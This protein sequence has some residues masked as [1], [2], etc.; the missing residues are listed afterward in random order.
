MRLDTSHSVR[1][2]MTML[3]LTAGTFVMYALPAA[4][5]TPDK[6]TRITAPVTLTVQ[7]GSNYIRIAPDNLPATVSYVADTAFGPIPMALV[8]G[9]TLD[10]QMVFDTCHIAWRWSVEEAESDRIIEI[11]AHE[12]AKIYVAP[13][14]C[15]VTT[16]DTTATS[17]GSY[18]WRGTTYS[19]TGDYPI[20]FTNAAGC[21]SIRTLRLTVY[22]QPE[23]RDTNAVVWDSI[24]WY[25][26][27]YKQ[28]GDFPIQRYDANGCDFTHTLH[29][30]VHTTTYDSYAENRC[31]S[32]QY[33]G[34]KYT[35]TGVYA[36]TV[37]DSAGN[38][39]I[40]T[41]SLTIPHS[42]SGEEH[43]EECDTYTWHGKTYTASG[44][45]RDTIENVAGCD[46]IVT[47]YLTIHPSSHNTLPAI[48]ECDS[49][50]WGDTTIYDSG[51]YTRRFTSIHGCDSVV[52]QTITV[53]HPYYDVVDR[54]TAYDSYTWI[55]GTT[56]TSSKT[57]PAY[58]LSTVDGC[59]SLITLDLTIRHLQVKDTFERTLCE[60]YMPYDWYGK[61]YRESGVYASDTIQGKEVGGIYMDTV[62]YVN[63]TV[64]PVT[65]GDTT[66]TA[67]ESFDWHGQTYTASGNYPLTLTNVHGC[68]STV[69]LHLT[70]LSKTR[71]DTTATACESFDWHGQNYTASGDYPLTLT[72]AAGC[73]S[74]VT[75]HLTIAHPTT[76]DT[77]ATA[78]ESFHW[79]GQNYTS[80]GDYPFTLTSAAGCDST[81][82][83]HLTISR[84]LT[85]DTTATACES[86]DWHG[87]N[88]T[89]SGDYPF[90]LTSTEGCDS[91]VTL[92]LTINHPTTGDTT[93]TACESF[94]W[95]GASYTNS[96]DYSHALTN[97]AG[98]DSTV[99]LHLTIYKPTTGDTTA[100]A[101]NAFTWYGDTYISS[102]NYSRLMPG[103]NSHG[104]DSTLI[105]HLTISQP[106]TGE[107]TRSVCD[108]VQWNGQ[109]YRESGNYTYSTQN[110][111]G[112]DS[113]ATLHLTV[114]HPTTDSETR[115]ACVS[116]LWHGETYRTS[117]E[118][119]FT[120]TNAAGCDSVVT[121][122]LTIVDNC[123]TYDTVY[124]CHGL[125]TEHEEKV[126]D[127]LIRRYVP[128]SYESPDEW[129]SME[130]VFVRGEGSRTLLDL[131]RAEQNLYAHYVDGL[132]P[133]VS[134][135]WS[136]RPEGESAYRM[137]A[138]EQEAQ[139]VEAGVIALQV[140][141]L[142]GHV[143]R[144]NIPTDVETVN[145]EG[146]SGHKMLI[147]GELIILR[148]GVKYTI[149]GNKIR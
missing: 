148:G 131:H 103:A 64:L 120:L 92:H 111:A 63:L 138:A 88:Y 21:D 95:Y 119:S 40:T 14:V 52:T 87:Q 44:E 127:G 50:V 83:L 77:T 73:D 58:S 98:C 76:G 24:S 4:G 53:G 8:T 13:H 60:T 61:S 32:I 100:T 115:E 71:G 9:D 149:L 128:Y 30:T 46:S 96:G 121:L 15:L 93:A 56:Y 23:N 70:I 140:Q 49:Y 89:S 37:Y 126:T 99:T 34:K 69:T 28:S 33:N 81:V 26:T 112:C 5:I 39:T 94:T 65:T 20:T 133:V 136:Y 109:W 137:L 54:V 105:L 2:L 25:G 139:W 116:Y 113:T 10:A 68:D 107:E 75:L 118:Y 125:N 97:A 42:S 3:L 62:H 132:E 22:P 38:R 90:T 19:A 104:C 108:S 122:Y 48:T 145:E 101:C 29:L 78:C 106:S 142:C 124:F 41:L 1:M 80:S 82:T 147:N 144:S 110:V 16:S 6:A 72:N 134:I 17:C 123:A 11:I 130:G 59:D 117:G 146:T 114:N 36:D 135:H 47:L 143:Y 67:C 129:N 31:D 45:Y 27:T 141:F 51:T 91:T 86:F 79:Y 12:N 35:E 57:G 74:I 7:S 102:G 55:N 66:A 18:E 84:Q 43:I 85:G